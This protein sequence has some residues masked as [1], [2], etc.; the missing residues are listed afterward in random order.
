MVGSGLDESI[1]KTRDRGPTTIGTEASCLSFF[2]SLP[3]N[4][5]VGNKAYGMAWFDFKPL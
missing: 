3:S 5:R 2:T 1:A 4:N